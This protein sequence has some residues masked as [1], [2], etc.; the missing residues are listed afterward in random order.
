MAVRCRLYLASSEQESILREHCAHARFVWNLAV[1]QQAWWRP[2]RANPPGP[3]ARQRQLTE[4]RAAEPWLAAGSS[5]IQQQALRDFDRALSAFFDKANPSGRPKFRSAKRGRQGFVIRDTKIRRLN[6]R[7]GAVFIPK[8]GYMRFRWTRPAPENLRM[9]RVTA[10][11]SGHW[12]VSFPAPQPPVPRVPAGRRVG[13]DRGVRTALVTSAGQHYRAP[14]ISDRRAT[15]YLEL[16]QRLARQSRE[17]A[18]RATTLRALAT[19]DAAT[20]RRRKDWAEKISTRLVRANDVIVLEDLNI[21]AMTKRPAPK[22][23]PDQKGIYLP[24]RARPRARLSH[25]ILTSAWGVLGRRVDQK[26]A[27]SGVTVVFIDPRGTSQTC[28][29]CGHADPESRESQAVFRCTK[30]GHYDHADR[31]A[32]CNILARGL[33]ALGGE[34]PALAPGYGAQSPRKSLVRTSAA[35]T[36]RCAPLSAPESGPLIPGP[37]DANSPKPAHDGR[38]V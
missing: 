7:W 5:S 4:A 28:R 15:R 10:D 3:A 17:S 6:R 23:S 34:I 31:N 25:G 30:C 21:R 12:H 26:A 32:A 14:R 8:C 29:R 35:G 24:N 27:A 22:P 13:I 18:R 20:T 1:E 11:S 38:G 9:A 36:G 16:Q 33:I 2:G 37:V 19:I